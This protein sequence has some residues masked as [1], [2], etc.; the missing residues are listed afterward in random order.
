[1]LYLTSLQTLTPAPLRLVDEINQGMDKTNE[2]MIFTQIAKT[3]CEPDVPQYFLITP[4]LLPDL[5]YTPEMTI[6][7]IF[8]GPHI[9]PSLP[10]SEYLKKLRG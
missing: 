9:D 7:C 6:L 10:I 3:A 1:M 8:N 4:K 2:A 5:N